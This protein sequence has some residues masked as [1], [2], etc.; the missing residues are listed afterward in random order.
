MDILGWVPQRIDAE[1]CTQ[2]ID[3]GVLL[4]ATPARG[5]ESWIGQKEKLN[6]HQLQP[7]F[8]RYHGEIRIRDSP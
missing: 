5:E 2:K 4:G 3:W 8:S 6:C 7:E 1:I